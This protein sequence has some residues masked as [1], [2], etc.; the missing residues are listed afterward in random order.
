[1]FI[2]IYKHPY[3]YQHNKFPYNYVHHHIRIH[4]NTESGVD[5]N[6]VWDCF[7]KRFMGGSVAQSG[8]IAVGGDH[9]TNDISMVMK[10][11]LTRAE[12]LKIEHGSVM[13]QDEDQDEFIVLECCFASDCRL[14]V[15]S[16]YLFR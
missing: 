11:P 15:D 7:P 8:C 3:T 10:V 5:T 12:R 1:M 9:I 4:I 16:G 6:S 13:V 2:C 14:V